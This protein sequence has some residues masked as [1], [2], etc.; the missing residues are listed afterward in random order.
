MKK[1]FALMMASVIALSTPMAEVHA[2]SNAYYD[3]KNDLYIPKGG[4]FKCEGFVYRVT[5]PIT[6]KRCIG[7]VEITGFDAD[8]DWGWN[9]GGY[10]HVSDL[11][12]DEYYHIVGIADNAFKDNLNIRKFY[13]P[14]SLKYVGESAFEGCSNLKIFGSGSEKLSKIK[15]RAFYNCTSLKE[16]ILYENALKHVGKDAFRNDKH[17]IKIQTYNMSTK[18]EARVKKLFKKAGAKKTYFKMD[19]YKKVKRDPCH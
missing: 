17:K 1:V 15:S 6:K 4:E 18:H 9:K 8:Y 19:Y 10:Y 14:R 16:F 2:E 12:P 3:T 7:E 11:W 13:T 5:K